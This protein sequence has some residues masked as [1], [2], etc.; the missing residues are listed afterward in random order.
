M[1]AVQLSALENTVLK[2]FHELYKDRGFPDV[3]AI[4]VRRRDFTRGG[5]YVDLESSLEVAVEDGY[6]DFGGHFIEMTG[7]PNGIMAVVLVNNR[8]VKLLELTVYGGEYWNGEERD[9]KIV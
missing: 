6:L 4:R 5:R 1:N 2:R 9:W 3:D 8:R 7:L